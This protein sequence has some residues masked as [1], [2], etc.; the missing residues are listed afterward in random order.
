MGEKFE[1]LSTEIQELYWSAP[2]L[3]PNSVIFIVGG[4][5]SIPDYDLN[6]IR[7]KYPTIGCN[8]AFLDF[9]WIDVIY[10][11]DCKVHTWV[12]GKSKY[13]RQFDEYQGLKV[14]SCPDT[15]DDPRIKTLFRVHKGI[16]KDRRSIGW[17]QNTGL[18][19]INL[20]VHFG[21]RKVILLGFDMKLSKD[22]R[23]NYHDYHLAK[24]NHPV[25]TLKKH[26]NYSK[27]VAADVEKLGIEVINATPGSALPHWPIKHFEEVLNE[28]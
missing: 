25:D 12:S 17:N 13:R 10:F 1:D 4:G 8:L 2:I 15:R 16:V 20:A 26:I 18:S 22:G 5:P 14:S 27:F 23:M 24:V 9:T 6:L 21:A 19:A 3:W 7:G 11:G 28:L